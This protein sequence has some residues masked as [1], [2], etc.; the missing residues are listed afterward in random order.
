MTFGQAAAL[1]TCQVE[2]NPSLKRRTRKYHSETLAALLKS[3]PREEYTF[4]PHA[5]VV[6]Y[7]D[8]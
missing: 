3:W 6:E 1:Y 4:E 8:D 2:E 5:P 7:T